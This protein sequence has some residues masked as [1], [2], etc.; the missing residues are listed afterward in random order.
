MLPGVYGQ[1]GA[2]DG[3][4]GADWPHYGGTQ[5]SWRYSALSQVNTTNVKALTPIWMG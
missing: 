3:A 4:T 5:L 1:T 2:A